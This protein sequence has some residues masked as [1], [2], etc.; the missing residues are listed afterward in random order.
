MDYK[1]IFNTCQGGIGV[2]LRP[3]AE[4]SPGDV[5]AAISRP[6]RGSPQDKREA[7]SLPYG[8][9]P[10]GDP[11]TAFAALTSLRMTKDG[12]ILSEAK[13]PPVRRT[14]FFDSLRSLRMTEYSK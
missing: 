3:Q 12:V 11:S 6:P 2:I 14:R 5:G 8:D 10:G 7:D 13:D 1:L 4:E 9:R